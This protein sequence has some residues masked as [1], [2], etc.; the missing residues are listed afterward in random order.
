[1]YL[2]GLVVINVVTASGGWGRDLV[3]EHFAGSSAQ[4]SL[5]YSKGSDIKIWVEAGGLLM[6]DWNSVRS[7]FLSGLYCKSI[8][9]KYKSMHDYYVDFKRFSLPQSRPFPIQIRQNF[10]TKL[11]FNVQC[12]IIC[13]KIK[14]KNISIK[15][16]VKFYDGWKQHC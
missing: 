3:D 1:M 13:M 2:R 10:S 4:L 8:Q 7:F 14:R 16:V 6:R 15:M 9:V 5:Q 12:L 11:K